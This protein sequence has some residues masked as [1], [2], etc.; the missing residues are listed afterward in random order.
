MALILLD[1]D[2][3]LTDFAAGVCKL[4]GKKPPGSDD[5]GRSVAEVAGINPG[6]MWRRIDEAGARFWSEL[7]PTPFANELVTMCRKVGEVVIATSPSSD[8]GA[9]AGK[10][11]WLQRRFGKRFRDFA[12]TPRKELLAAPGRLLIDD[13]PKHV[14]A[15][16]AA[17]GAAVLVPTWANG[18]LESEATVLAPIEAALAALQEN[19]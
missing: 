17:G 3:V 14:D 7:E 12:I 9:A 18:E 19:T 13:T 11:A 8:P 15:F 5:R 4:F 16:R 1:M 10:V 2:G 6:L